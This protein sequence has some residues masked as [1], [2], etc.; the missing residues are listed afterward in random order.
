MADCSITERVYSRRT[1][2][3]AGSGAP[4]VLQ[5]HY[6]R[7][8]SCLKIRYQE[9]RR[10][11]SPTP[12]N[13]SHMSASNMC[14]S[15]HIFL[16][17][18]HHMMHYGV[19]RFTRRRRSVCRHFLAGC[20][21]QNGMFGRLFVCR[22]QCA[23]CFTQARNGLADFFDVD[24]WMDGCFFRPVLT[25]SIHAAFLYT[26]GSTSCLCSGTFP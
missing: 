19:Q 6:C 10:T 8:R 12:R 16:Q 7:R 26:T 23:G 3:R 22:V 25:S 4:S 5:P 1:S 18:P 2:A 20:G 14:L 13:G 24:G 11:C 21:V 15:G 17:I 9:I